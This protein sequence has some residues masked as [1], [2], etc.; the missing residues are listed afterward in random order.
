MPC[1]AAKPV[2]S[3]APMPFE[4][5]LQKMP[6]LERS[7]GALTLALARDDAGI[8][9]I[10]DLYQRDPCR[11][12]FPAPEPGDV[13]QAVMLTTS[14]G[15]AGGDRIAASIASGAGTRA[16][17]TTQAAEKVYRARAENTLF[18]VEISAGAGAWLEWLPQE[19]ILFDGARF[20]RETRIALAADAR[21]LAAEIVVFG[22]AARGERLTAGHY[23]DRWRVEREGRVVW[24]DA[25][26]WNGDPAAALGH[27]AG[28]AGAGAMATVI[29]A[30][31][32]AVQHLVGAR[33]ALEDVRSRAAATVVNGL[34]VARF[35]ADNAQIL[36]SD[37][38]QLWCKLR[39]EA[40]NLPPV[41][42]RTW[43]T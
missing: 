6:R 41:L 12:L 39:T 5:G 8:T 30:G 18:S 10:D 21:L 36:R 17:V 13:F 35:L 27:P 16:L 14:G 42:P 24:R 33:A 43:Y 22:R 25:V 26:G 2:R 4:P 32:G 28:F 40:G 7:D 11:A 31:P 1:C 3:R 38:A 34:L 15:L 29:F 23:L 20:R 37:F 9:G 19:T